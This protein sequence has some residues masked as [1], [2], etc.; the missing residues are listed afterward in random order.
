M[1]NDSE[2]MATWTC[3]FIWQTD[4][5]AMC[6][7]TSKNIPIQNIWAHLQ[8]Q[9]YMYHPGFSTGHELSLTPAT[10]RRTGVPSEMRCWSSGLH[11][12]PAFPTQQNVF[13][14]HMSCRL[15][16]GPFLV[17]NNGI[18]AASVNSDINCETFSLPYLQVECTCSVRPGP[19]HMHR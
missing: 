3:M 15:N 19:G 14:T 7:K 2:M 17:V 4:L 6:V 5:A 10:S 18:F 8:I 11:V 1:N 12:T 16:L 9:L 13:C